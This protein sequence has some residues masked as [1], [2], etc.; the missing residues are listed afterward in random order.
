MTSLLQGST[1]IFIPCI[2]NI[3]ASLYQPCNNPP[4]RY[5]GKV[6]TEVVAWLVQGCDEVV[7]TLDLSRPLAGLKVVARWSQ[8]CK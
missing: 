1:A 4:T 5:S 3:V 2:D 7:Q 6:G 8:G